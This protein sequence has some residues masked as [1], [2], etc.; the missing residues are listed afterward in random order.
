[1]LWQIRFINDKNVKENLRM[2]LR[3]KCRYSELFW[4]AFTR[5]WNL[6]EEILRISPYSVRMQEN[7]DQNN[8][9]YGHFSN[10]IIEI[11]K[12]S[13][14]KRLSNCDNLSLEVF[15]GGWERMCFSGLITFVRQ[16]Y[17]IRSKFSENR[18]WGLVVPHE[19]NLSR[20]SLPNKS[21]FCVPFWNGNLEN[22]NRSN[23]LVTW[24]KWSNDA[25]ITIYSSVTSF[26]KPCNVVYFSLIS[27]SYIKNKITHVN[28]VIWTTTFNAHL[29][30]YL[31]LFL[32]KNKSFPVCTRYCQN[33]EW[34]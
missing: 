3:K 2:A 6:Y 34:I 28:N 25:M 23:L 24:A 15:Q 11:I 32:K 12:C 30:T 5:I 29:N 22:K 17:K 1:M 4:F 26:Y 31:H 13:Y 14:D 19:L 16:G 20:F 18:Y 33:Q 9:E 10:G 8:S 27:L 7:G 21:G